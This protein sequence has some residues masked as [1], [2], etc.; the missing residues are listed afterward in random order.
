MDKTTNTS[1]FKI[2]ASSLVPCKVGKV[3][4]NTHVGIPLLSMSD[5]AY[6]LELYLGVSTHCLLLKFT[7]A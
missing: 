2:V 3:A 4:L 1:R 7:H 5:A 6:T